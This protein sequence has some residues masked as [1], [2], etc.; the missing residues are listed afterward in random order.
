MSTTA[1]IRFCNENK[2][3]GAV[4]LWADGYPW[5]V[6]DQILKT[7]AEEF[8]GEN[9]NDAID[10]LP[11]IIARFYGYDIVNDDEAVA[12]AAE[13]RLYNSFNLYPTYK[14]ATELVGSVDH[15]YT[16]HVVNGKIYY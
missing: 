5:A 15:E 7:L 13:K 2:E 9:A 12:N 8:D 1:L 10:D 6:R 11:V 16:V 4:V 14:R 3:N